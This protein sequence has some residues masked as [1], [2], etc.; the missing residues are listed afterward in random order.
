MSTPILGYPDHRLQYILDTDASAFGLGAVLSQIQ[1]GKERVIGY[2]SK[3]M[4]SEECNYCV[5]R[6][7]L[8]AVVTAVKHFRPYLYGQ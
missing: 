1:N 5:T 2:F 6:K 3:T 8:L 7:E 4:C